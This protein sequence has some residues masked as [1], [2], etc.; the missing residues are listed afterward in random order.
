MLLPNLK[1]L[2]LNV[3]LKSWQK[4]TKYLFI[5]IIIIIIKKPF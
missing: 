4:W 2:K 3:L 5:I 1:K